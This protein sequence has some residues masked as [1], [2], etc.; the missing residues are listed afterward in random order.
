[1]VFDVIGAKSDIHKNSPIIT[2]LE[3]NL[4]LCECMDPNREREL[5]PINLTYVLKIKNVI[6]VTLYLWL[7]KN[8]GVIV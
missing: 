1:M 5:N 6:K 8:G 2:K 7:N 3:H 4:K